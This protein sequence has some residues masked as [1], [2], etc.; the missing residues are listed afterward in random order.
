MAKIYIRSF[1]CQMARRDSE[2]LLGLFLE[3]GYVQATDEK[4]ADVVLINTC[5]V[6]EH[7]EDRA[8]SYAGTL[9]KLKY[10]EVN[11]KFG[12]G[13]SPKLRKARV[14]I[15]CLTN[16]SKS[17][18]QLDTFFAHSMQR[19][20]YIF[21]HEKDIL[22]KIMNQ[23]KSFLNVM[24]SKAENITSAWIKRWLSFHTNNH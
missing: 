12:E 2:A 22:K 18:I 17:N 16:Y 24:S 15:D 1:G 4:E 9:K 5:S 3:K 21:F 10:V 6:R 8:I 23:K 19:K 14:G 7:A 11:H 13:T 20:N